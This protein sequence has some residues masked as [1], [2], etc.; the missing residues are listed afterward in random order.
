M[1]KVE[2]NILNL[3]GKSAMLPKDGNILYEEISENL[4][5]GY[6]VTLNFVDVRFITPTFFNTAIGQLYAQY[7]TAFLQTQ[8]KVANLSISDRIL[9]VEV[10][11]RAKAYF[12][13]KA[14]YENKKKITP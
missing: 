4:E 10:V 5:D 12:K 13:E 3:I 1:K 7:D 9:L 6:I 11:Q 14:E 8:L 2:I